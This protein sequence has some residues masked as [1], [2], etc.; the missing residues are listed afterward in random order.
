MPTN[1]FY[2]IL[3]T[4]GNKV[5]Y[6]GRFQCATR[7]AAMTLLKE[8]IGRQNLSGLVFTITEFPIEVLR[9]VI[10]SIINKKPLPEGDIV[11]FQK[12][13]SKAS[14]SYAKVIGNKHNPNKAQGARSVRRR[15]G[16]F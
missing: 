1:K 6:E 9:E 16:Y 15:L 11:G 4:S 14:A 8:K 13:T 5:V 12:E 7:G 2:H 10:D 3:C